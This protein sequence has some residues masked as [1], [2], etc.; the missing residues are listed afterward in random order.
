M[1]RTLKD[2]ADYLDNVAAKIPMQ[3]TNEKSLRCCEVILTDLLRETPVDSGKAVSNWRVSLNSPNEEKLPSFAPGFKGST[4]LV[5][6][7]AALEAAQSVLKIKKPGDVL[8]ISNPLPYIRRLNDG[9]SSQAPAGFVERATLLG[10]LYSQ[11]PS[12]FN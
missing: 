8:Y 2:L 9:W 12:S 3:A 10:R 11:D 5:C 6:Q 7:Q 4:Q 1:G